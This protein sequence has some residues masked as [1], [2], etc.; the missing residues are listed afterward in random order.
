[1]RYTRMGKVRMEPPLPKIPNDIPTNA[2]HTYPIHSIV[3]F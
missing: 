3:R 2:A 1:M